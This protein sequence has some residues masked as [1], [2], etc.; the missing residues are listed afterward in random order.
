MISKYHIH[1]KQTAN[2]T[3]GKKHKGTWADPEGVKGYKPPWKITSCLM[4]PE[5][6]WYGQRTDKLRV[7]LLLEGGP[8]VRHYVKYVDK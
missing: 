8:Y 3:E 4:F 1:R 5:K 2:G 7:Q 6:F